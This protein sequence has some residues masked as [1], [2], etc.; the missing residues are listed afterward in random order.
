MRKHATA[1]ERFGQPAGRDVFL[2]VGSAC[3]RRTFVLSESILRQLG[4]RW[5]CLLS[6]AS[7]SSGHCSSRLHRRP[8]TLN[9]RDDRPESIR[10]VLLIATLQFDKVPKVLDF[11]DIVHV[12]D[13]AVRYEAHS[14][15]AGYMDGWLDPYRDRLRS[16]GYEEWLYIAK[17]F[18]YEAEYAQLAEFL[19]VNCEVDPSGKKLVRSGSPCAIGGRVPLDTLGMSI[20]IPCWVGAGVRS[21]FRRDSMGQVSTRPS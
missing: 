4:P 8:K 15:L 19:V 18:G 7:T 14:L 20:S 13:V 6:S 17:Q 11:S 10:I 12:T 2:L 3:N 9:L 5:K 16:R 21:L 1:N